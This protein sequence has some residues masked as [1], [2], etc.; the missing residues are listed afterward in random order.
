[1]TE[2]IHCTKCSAEL[3]ARYIGIDNLTKCYSCNNEIG[4]VVFPAFYKDAEQGIAG[5]SIIEADDAGCFY[6]PGKKAALPCDSCGR[7]LCT[8]CA[9][10]FDGQNMCP[11]CLETGQ[12]KHKIST[13][14]DRRKV[15]DT[16]ALELA[17]VPMLIFWFT[18]FTAPMVLIIT[19]MHWKKPGS[20]LRTS[21]IRFVIACIIAIPQIAIWIFVVAGAING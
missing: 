17:I 18:I 21:K 7:F 1:M 15:Y 14:E 12:K 11:V 13:L 10:E 5:E 9:I 2:I 20:I 19:A 6:H 8:L 3:D 4:A 16:V